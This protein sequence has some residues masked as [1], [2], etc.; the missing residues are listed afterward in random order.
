MLLRPHGLGVRSPLFFPRE[1]RR[2][3]AGV[4]EVCGGL[5]LL[6]RSSWRLFVW[7]APP[8][9]R[10]FCP[11]P[12]SARFAVRAWN[13]FLFWVWRCLR[14]W[15]SG[16]TVGGGFGCTPKKHHSNSVL[17]VA[18]NCERRTG[19]RCTRR[20]AFGMFSLCVGPSSID[21]RPCAPCPTVGGLGT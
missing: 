2:L 14:Q 19:F 7:F 17:F 15:R 16:C 6:L 4:W 8:W 18:I 10:E 9:E 13:G 11:V 1:L 12:L 5:L 21:T 3:A 20:V